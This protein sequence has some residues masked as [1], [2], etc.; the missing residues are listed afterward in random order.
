[1]GAAGD[2]AGQGDNV[3]GQVSRAD[4]A[5]VCVAALTDPSAKNVTLELS[6]KKGVPAP[7]DQ[8]KT[9]FKGL[10]PD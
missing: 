10:Q 4:V 1:M 7:A 3:A 9:L 6:S 2:D 8:L 5:R